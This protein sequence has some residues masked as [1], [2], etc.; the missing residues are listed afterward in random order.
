MKPPEPNRLR[1][2]VAPNT[3]SGFDTPGVG[4]WLANGA[5][6]GGRPKAGA[7]PTAPAM[8]R[9]R[10]SITARGLGRLGLLVAAAGVL[11]FLNAE[12]RWQE[13]GLGMMSA[14][15]GMALLAAWPGIVRSR[16]AASGLS[17]V[18]SMAVV[19]GAPQWAAVPA[20]GAGLLLLGLFLLV[21][22][23]VAW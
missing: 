14:G 3:I 16:A 23:T 5:T 19:L 12:F 15:I 10:P 4:S 18:P 13:I 6:L 11:P 22:A 1:Q 7:P 17:R 20:I 9:S 8:A 2:S 21:D